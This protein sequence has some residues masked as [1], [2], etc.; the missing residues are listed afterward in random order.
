VGKAGGKPIGAMP[1]SMKHR[2]AALSDEYQPRGNRYQS[3]LAAG[4]VSAGAAHRGTR[5]WRVDV[6]GSTQPTAPGA[7]PHSARGSPMRAGQAEATPDPPR[8]PLRQPCVL[9]SEV[10]VLVS[11]SW[12][13]QQQALPQR[14]RG[15]NAEVSTQNFYT[16]V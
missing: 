5:S 12:T 9:P 14:T 16:S 13:V 7:S 6:A 10:V 15:F 1:L 8:P 4:K 3:D 11:R 2:K